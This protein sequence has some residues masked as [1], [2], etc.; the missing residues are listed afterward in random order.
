M[1]GGLA[2]IVGLVL[3]AGESARGADP[4]AFIKA[5]EGGVLPQTIEYPNDTGVLQIF[6]ADAAVDMKHHPFFM[7]L[8]P[9]GRACVTCH[10]PSDGMS[11]S[12]ATARQRWQITQGGDPVFNAVDGKNCPH[13][14]QGNPQSHSLLL[15]KGLFR[16]AMPWPPKDAAGRRI[17]PEFDIAVVSD[18]TGCNTSAVYGLNAPDPHV[19]VYRRPR[20]AANAKYV[21]P[22]TPLGLWQVR[23]GT[24]LA[25]DPETGNRLADNLMADGRATTLK[26]QMQDAMKSHMEAHQMPPGSALDLIRAFEL[27]IYAA[28]VSDKVGGSL[29]SGG[30][31]LG[32]KTLAQGTPGMLGAFPMR[33][34]FPELEG[35]RTRR[36]LAQM[37]T[38]PIFRTQRELPAKRPD[39]DRETPQQRA[40]RDSVA[41]GYDIFMY[42]SFLIRDVSN[43]G[44]LLGNPAQQTCSACHNMQSTGL[45][46]APGYL[47]LGTTNYPTATP[48]PDLPLFKV[49]CHQDAPPHPYLDRE[50]YTRDPGRALV[51]GRCAD[52]GQITAQQM[53]ALAARAPY[54]VDGSAQTLRQV[55]DF[56]ERRFRI[57]LTERDKD[58]LV[59]FMRIL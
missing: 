30:A 49:T 48:A 56:Y 38:K 3:L 23:S 50:I 9:D 41:R 59:N 39:E 4:S 11:L 31:M 15:S 47:D 7:P 34:M 17:A 46:N 44:R 6:N 25:V 53:R 33:P 14:P 40:F 43:I 1:A 45:D 57:G 13:L 20:V 10:Q 22:P 29:Q 35:W 32:P 51:T 18:P 19:S 52:V 8:Q 21:E 5:G 27:Q 36:T 54:F 58:D 2:A 28:Q 55:V 12:A 16:I 37:T 42:R 26:F 24:V